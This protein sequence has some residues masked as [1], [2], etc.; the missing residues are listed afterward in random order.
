MEIKYV[1]Q[2]GKALTLS[3]F[4][5]AARIKNGRNQ[6]GSGIVAAEFA[7]KYGV[8]LESF[9]PPKDWSVNKSPEA[10]ANASLHQLKEWEDLDPDDK[11]LIWTYLCLDHPIT[12]GIPAW[13][14]EVTLS[15]LRVED[16][17]IKEGFDNSW[18]TGYGVN[19]RG[20]LSGR[21][22]DFDEAGVI[23][24]VEPAKA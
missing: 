19:G 2:G 13:G 16:G 21:M 22:Q 12:V 6:G 7:N 11:P 24:S 5:G 17:R 8:P 18:G 4:Y 14:H 1:L 10:A 15:F 20:V 23:I 9:H 3:A